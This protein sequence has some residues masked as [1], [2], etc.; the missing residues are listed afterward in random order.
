MPEYP[1]ALVKLRAFCH[2][3]SFLDG[4]LQQ[5]LDQHD[6]RR[7]ADMEVLAANR[8]MYED[9]AN[10]SLSVSTFLFL[11]FLF[12]NISPSFF[13]RILTFSSEPARRDDGGDDRRPAPPS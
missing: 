2:V 12:R 1:L 4:R 10:E 6:A 9:T 7:K 3:K 13:V 8:K 11:P 5:E